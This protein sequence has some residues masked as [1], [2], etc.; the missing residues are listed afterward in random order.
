MSPLLETAGVALVALLGAWLGR[1]F[2]RLSKPWW[3]IG[4]ALPMLLLM[5]IGA[6]R[7]KSELEFVPPFCWLMTGRI[8]F[9]LSGLITTMLLSTPLSRLD[10]PR[11]RTAVQLLM[12]VIVSTVSL[13]PF[14]APAFNRGFLAHLQTKI[15]ANG[16]CR[17]STDYTCGPAAAV[18]HLRQLGFPAEEGAIAI[19]AHTS[20]AMGTPPDILADTLRSM[21]AQKG[22][23]CQYRS[24]QS[25]A[26][27]NRDGLT[28]AVIK[29][30]FLVDHYVAVLRVQEDKIIVGD[31]A[32]G[33]QNYTPEE[34]RKIW[35]FTGVVL[36]RASVSASL[37]Y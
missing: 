18:T 6:A 4:Y 23:V 20:S 24:Y 26:E 21:Y 33:V 34:F 25:V 10:K 30:G 9:A 12:L 31:P 16:I 19:Q 15:D 1:R 8:Q 17:Q 11:D 13:W 3:V 32:V 22:L 37:N 2:S 29:F 7:R 27:L 28:L 36:R 35:R 14:L 5:L